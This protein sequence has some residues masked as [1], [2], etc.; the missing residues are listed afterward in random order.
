MADDH[1]SVS[2]DSKFAVP[3]KNLIGLIVVTAFAVGGYYNI[4]DRIIALETQVALNLEEIEENDDW[5]DDFQPPPEVQDTVRRVRDL[6][7]QVAVLE[8]RL[9]ALVK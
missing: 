5:I 8:A 2:E 7:L 9:D 3:L 1:V 4:N 6:E